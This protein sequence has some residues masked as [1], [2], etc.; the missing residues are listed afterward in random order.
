M[1][2]PVQSVLGV[3]PE[4]AIEKMRTNLP[5]RFQNPDGECFMQG[6]LVEID[7]KTGKALRVERVSI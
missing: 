5:V 4:L 1:T 2:G 3:T 7:K 6:L